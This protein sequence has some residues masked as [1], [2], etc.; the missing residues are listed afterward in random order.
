ML[1]IQKMKPE[2]SVG[3]VFQGRGRNFDEIEDIEDG[4]EKIRIGPDLREVYV[5]TGKQ[6]PIGF[7]WLRRQGV[8]ETALRE[9]VGAV[10]DGNIQPRGYGAFPEKGPEIE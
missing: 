9:P 5:D 4:F 7:Y 6:L 10:S 2:A 3:P 1:K 8:V